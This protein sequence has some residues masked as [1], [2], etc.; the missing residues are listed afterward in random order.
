RSATSSSS[1]PSAPSSNRSDEAPEA[2][3]VVA[4]EAVGVDLELHGG[5]GLV[6]AAPPGAG[7]AGVAVADRDHGERLVVDLG[8]EDV[9]V[10]ADGDVVPAD[11]QRRGEGGAGQ[12][13]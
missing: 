1:P 2:A 8:H 13:D 12:V 6:L 11:R 7:Q 10:I 4:H 3:G 5:A 9:A